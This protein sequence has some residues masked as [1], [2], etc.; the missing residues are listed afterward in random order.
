MKKL[1]TFILTTILAASLLALP[2]SAEETE[3][4]ET[5]KPPVSIPDVLTEPFGGGPMIQFQGD[6]YKIEFDTGETKAPFLTSDKRAVIEIVHSV[7]PGRASEKEKKMFA[8]IAAKNGER[9]AATARI[10]PLYFEGHIKLDRNIRVS[11]DLP[12]EA[13]DGGYDLEMFHI[14]DDGTV[15]YL[16]DADLQYTT[17]PDGSI[18]RIT[19]KTKEFSTFF[20]A[21]KGLDLSDYLDKSSAEALKSATTTNTTT[22]TVA[23]TTT[24]ETTSS[25]DTTAENKSSDSNITTIALVSAAAGGGGVL[26]GVLIA[27]V[28]L[29]KK[30]K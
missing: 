13:L 19:F 12:A 6:G 15:E 18:G 14:K 17:A 26:I 11:I 22:T 7:E 29:K 5:K 27:I 2:C 4:K 3:P 9:D 21:K 8:D 1:I 25:V 24:P 10:Y 20:T 28:I 23:T 30:K 16:K